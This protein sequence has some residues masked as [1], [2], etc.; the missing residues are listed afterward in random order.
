M[1]YEQLLYEVSDGVATVTLNRPEQRNALSD[2]MLGELVDAFGRVRDDD[3]VRA[4]V[5]TGAGEKAFM[6]GGDI[7]GLGSRQGL[8]HYQEFATLVHRVEEL[9]DVDASGSRR[10]ARRT[11]TCSPAGWAWRSPATC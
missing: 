10:C 1:S 3:E 6:A 7:A 9:A 4:V 8:A 5:L 2:V 11:G